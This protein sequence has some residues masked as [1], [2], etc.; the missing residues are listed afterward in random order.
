MLAAV[1]GVGTLACQSYSD[2]IRQLLPP[3]GW[4]FPVSTTKASAPNVTTADLQEQLKPVAIDLAGGRLSEGRGKTSEGLRPQ[5]SISAR[6]A[7][8]YFELSSTLHALSCSLLSEQSV[9]A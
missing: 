5:R 7:T 2:E 1:V 9:P 8:F 3:F 6:L 4:L